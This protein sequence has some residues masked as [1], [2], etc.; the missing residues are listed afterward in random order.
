MAH[1]SLDSGAGARLG[2]TGRS[3]VEGQARQHAR[4]LARL[5]RAGYAAKGIIFLVIGG[6]A[7]MTAA[8][9]GGGTTD[10]RGALHFI[11]ASLLG[12]ALLAAMGAGLLGFALWSVIAQALDAEDRGRE[13]KGIALRVGKTVTG[14]AY[15][16]LGVE[17]LRTVMYAAS[18]GGGGARHWSARAMALPWGRWLV[19]AIGAGVIGYALYQV[20]KGA[21]K[22]LRKRLHLMGEDTA[23]RWV[24]RVARFGIIARAVVFMIIGWFLVQAGLHREPG[25]VG[26]IGDAL[27]TLAGQSYGPWLLGAVAVGLM[28]YGVWELV[29]ARYRD[30]P[31]S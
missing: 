21:R 27:G 13:P 18:S 24:L 16:A 20:W 3:A 5:A 28:A 8:G 10:S 12:R 23:H 25:E 22:D 19:A 1:I 26:G 2:A 11:G 31:V 29:N 7:L 6:L 30:L 17:A 15:G 9:S 14:L 4:G